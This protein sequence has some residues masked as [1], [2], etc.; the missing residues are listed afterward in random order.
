MKTRTIE[1]RTEVVVTPM[2]RAF[3]SLLLRKRH[4]MRATSAR[5]LF[6]ARS[7]VLS[8]LVMIF[9]SASHAQSWHVSYMVIPANPTSPITTTLP[10]YGSVRVTEIP[11]PGTLPFAFQTEPG[12]ENGSAGAY[13]WGTDTNDIN[14]VTYANSAKYI[15]KFE[16]LNGPPDP[17]KLLLIV[18]GLAS[19]T[20]ATVSQLGNLAGELPLIN[21]AT[22]TTCLAPHGSGP[23][24]DTTTCPKTGGD[25]LYSKDDGDPVNTGWAPFQAAG[26]ISISVAGRQRIPTLTVTFSQQS[27]DGIGFTLGYADVPGPCCPPWDANTMLDQLQLTQTGGALGNI[28]YTFMNSAPYK[29]QIQA[30]IDYLHSLNSAIET[31]TLR[32]DI[33]DHGPSGPGTSPSPTG[34]Q[35]GPYEFT[36]WSCGTLPCQ[37][38]LTSGGGGNLT[39]GPN[40][41]FDP[42]LFT[43]PVNRWY[44][45]TTYIYL[46]NNARYPNEIQFWPATCSSTAVDLTVYAG[47]ATPAR[48]MSPNRIAV[49]VREPGAT[50]GRVVMLPF[51][52]N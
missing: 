20:Y 48:D 46:N 8:G 33:S 13:T 39:N 37:G 14:T 17:N 49:E 18:I 43:L 35:I 27:G 52:H 22:S 10:G 25:V 5:W 26:P 24:F 29:N 31:I 44:Q 30:Y 34:T 3:S 41:V 36:E 2:K 23:P 9:A 21:G 40:E 51:N 16:F 32:W 28:S 7:L 1:Q 38:T 4:R 45:I 12:A 42:S 19:G 11:D 50:K 6:G 15:V 47:P